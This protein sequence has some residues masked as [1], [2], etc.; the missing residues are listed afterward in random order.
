M[1]MLN[2]KLRNTNSSSPLIT[3]ECGNSPSNGENSVLQVIHG[4]SNTNGVFRNNRRTG[5]LALK[6]DQRSEKGKLY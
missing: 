6:C 5:K 1:R 4:L 3:V 2:Y